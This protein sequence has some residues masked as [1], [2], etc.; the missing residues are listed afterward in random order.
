MKVALPVM[1]TQAGQVIIQLADNIMVGHVGTTALAGVSFANALFMIGFFT[2]LGF[3]QG[4]TP[5]VGECIGRGDT[6]RT[7]ALLRNSF[8]TNSAVFSVTGAAMAGIGLFMPFMGQD[9]DI[10][11]PAQSYYFLNLLSLIPIVFFVTS[12]QF[13]E[14]IGNTSHAMW[15]TM[16][17]NMV[18]ILLNWILIFGH[19]GAPR[20][21]ASGAALATLIS[22]TLAASLFVLIIRKSAV[23]RPYTDF[24]GKWFDRTVQRE[25]FSLSVPV[26]LSCLLEV[27]AFNFASVMV[28]WMGK[29]QQAGHQIAYSLSQI[30]FLIAC[31]VGTA[32]TIRVSHQYGARRYRETYMAGKASIHMSIVYM[33]VC[34]VIFVAL[35]QVLPLAF[36]SDPEVIPVASRLLLIIAVYQFSDAVQ[37]SSMSALRGLQDTRRPMLYAGI[38]YYLVAIPAGYLMGIVLGMGPDGV[39]LGLMLGLTTA[40]VLF[41]TRFRNICRKLLG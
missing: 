39:W 32:A 41:Y 7:A 29:V 11:A 38:S 36:T 18:N 21:G 14:G 30:S 40:A 23:Y 1:V 25:I 13:A 37:L 15:I 16:F 33:A 8:L 4:L 6:R 10:I 31:G 5:L 24:S 26:A 20:M 3:S 17:T 28:G 35:D 19:L 12:K 9:P 22:R 27:T 2:L 34:A